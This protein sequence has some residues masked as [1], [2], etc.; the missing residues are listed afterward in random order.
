MKIKGFIIVLALFFSYIIKAQDYVKLPSDSIEVVDDGN[1]NLIIVKNLSS[2]K[3]GVIDSV[4]KLVVPFQ[5]DYI[6]SFFDELALVYN[7]DKCGYLNTEGKVAI[8]LEYAAGNHFKNG[9]VIVIKGDF[10]Y[11]VID[12][13]N[14]IIIPFKYDLLQTHDHTSYGFRLGNEKSGLMNSQ[15]QV[16]L[17]PTYDNFRKKNDSLWIAK[18]DKKITI[19]RNNGDLHIPD[20]FDAIERINRA[21]L[22]RF[23]ADKKFGFLNEQYEVIIPAQYLNTGPAMG[24]LIAVFNGEK[25]GFIDRDNN[26][27]VAFIYDQVRGLNK[28]SCIVTKEG[29]SNIIDKNTNLRLE[30]TYKYIKRIPNSDLVF[31]DGHIYD[32]ELNRK[33]TDKVS[34]GNGIF[35]KMRN[36]MLKVYVNGKI[37]YLDSLGN[38]KIPAAYDDGAHFY[39]TGCTIVKKGD[40]WGFIKDNNELLTA[41]IY[42]SKLHFGSFDECNYLIVRD[43]LYGYFSGDRV[44]L[45]PQ[46]QELIVGED[47]SLLYRKG[48]RYGIIDK[49]TNEPNE[50]MYNKIKAS[51]LGYEVERAGKYGFLDKS[52]KTI[53]PLEYEYLED[54]GRYLVARLNGKFGTI[55]KTNQV[56]EDFVYDNIE[57]KPYDVIK[58]YK[59]GKVGTLSSAG[60]EL[61]PPIY[62]DIS[63]VDWR[64]IKVTI[65]E[66][67]EIID[68]AKLEQ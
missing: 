30:K 2:D 13:S 38:M 44:V 21:K 67:T 57:M 65:N 32:K 7:D 50:A 19:L 62:D 66:K 8:P 4:G 48:D 22:I 42:D 12:K 33:T 45:E 56:I 39:K 24:S 61:L 16:I 58:T 37:G 15:E 10:T 40:K 53:I 36:G 3:F 35:S 20:K 34:L 52:L 63:K 17:E 43:S 5:Y 59:D 54:R 11:G 26:L 23:T 46:F 1:Y 28:E 68:L 47:R 55:S 64:S 29:E 18:I 27:K 51:G 31:M 49:R 25:W 60:T 6:Y 14:N 41:F 9:K